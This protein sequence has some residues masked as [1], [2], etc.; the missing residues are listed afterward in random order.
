LVEVQAAYVDTSAFVK[1]Y[2]SREPAS[3]AFAGRIRKVRAAAS[4]ILLV[5][6]HSA[7]ARKVRSGDLGRPDL[8]RIRKKL[9]QDW[10]RVLKIGV[11]APVLAEAERLLFAHDLRAADAIHL[12]SALLLMKR[13]GAGMPLLTADQRMGAAAVLEGVEVEHFGLLH[14]TARDQQSD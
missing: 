12:A 10:S 3:A 7:F 9:K 11:T 1:L 5:E 6:T 8:E 13:A 2:D 14:I 4:P